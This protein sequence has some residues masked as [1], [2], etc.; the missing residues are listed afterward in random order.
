MKKTKTQ[1]TNIKTSLKNEDKKSA[2]SITELSPSQLRYL[3]KHPMDGSPVAAMPDP[4]YAIQAMIQGKI[5]SLLRIL[6]LIED[7][8]KEDPEIEGAAKPI[9]GKYLKPEYR[10]NIDPT[11]LE[12]N[13]ELE[14]KL[15][16]LPDEKKYNVLTWNDF[17][18]RRKE[19]LEEYKRSPSLDVFAPNTLRV[20]PLAVLSDY[21]DVGIFKIIQDDCN[22]MVDFLKH[23][24]KLNPVF[25]IILFLR[26]DEIQSRFDYLSGYIKVKYRPRE[27]I[28]EQARMAGKKGGEKPKKKQ[29]IILAVVKYLEKHVRL[30]DKSN[31][32]IAESFKK[33]VG[34][35]EPIIVNFNGCEWDVYFADKF[36]WAI[37]DTKNREKNKDK[38]IAY[39]TFMNSYI[40]EAKKN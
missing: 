14:K 30:K 17:R 6:G 38:S 5:E 20:F 10:E 28:S 16:T 22:D 39:T 7:Y 26:I 24:K 31:Y 11:N 4:K 19:R 21:T 35:N 23:V 13:I 36:I 1:K 27:I 33:N 37:P 8:K 29:P 9:L 18:K 3:V 12:E 32:E 15:G 34:K 2:L 25:L 40:S